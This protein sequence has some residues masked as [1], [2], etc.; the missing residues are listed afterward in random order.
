MLSVLSKQI[1]LQ[2]S[3]LNLYTYMYLRF[4]D[5]NVYRAE[6]DVFAFSVTYIIVKEATGPTA[7]VVECHCQ[8]HGKDVEGP[9][10]KSCDGCHPNRKIC[11]D[12]LNIEASVSCHRNYGWCDGV[13]PIVPEVGTASN[14]W[15]KDWC[16]SLGEFAAALKMP[17]EHWTKL[18]TALVP[19]MDGAA[20]WS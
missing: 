1:F 3:P 8:H 6:R 18:T 4:P 17:E 11:R 2:T 10:G 19:Q 14:A 13:S 15:T 9:D 16:S 5:I 20:R 7:S 12:R